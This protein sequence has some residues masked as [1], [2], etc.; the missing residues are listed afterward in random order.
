MDAVL[1]VAAQA[2]HRR[3]PQPPIS[4][5]KPC[6]NERVHRTLAAEVFPLRHFRDLAEKQRR[7]D[8][9][10]EVYNCE[11][12]H[13][14][15]GQQVPASRYRPSQRSMP[16]RLPEV[17]YDSHEIVRRVS[18]TKAYV[19]FKGCLWKVPQAF[20]GERLA[21]RP[22]ANRAQYG[23]FFAAHQVAIHYLVSM[24]NVYCI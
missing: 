22:S 14:A 20:C 8:P 21:I 15:L 16:D 3:H 10:R 6:K 12:P 1:G 18:T 5:A 7:F 23:D 11:R 9:W 24:K 2:W 17:E 4:P 19:S 13:E